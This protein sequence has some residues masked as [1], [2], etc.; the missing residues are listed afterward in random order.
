MMLLYVPYHHHEPLE[1]I[2]ATMMLVPREPVQNADGGTEVARP[3]AR[4][5]FGVAARPRHSPLIDRLTKPP[6]DDATSGDEL[7]DEPR[8]T[9]AAT[10]RGEGLGEGRGGW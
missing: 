2:M 3:W 9:T 10:A 8:Y 7:G 5:D 6:G 1:A 4:A